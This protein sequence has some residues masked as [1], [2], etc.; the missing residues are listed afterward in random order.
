MRKNTAACANN[1]P[2]SY[3]HARGDVGVRGDPALTLYRYLSP[4]N[5]EF[6]MAVVMVAST[7]IATLR[8][9]SMCAYV[10]FSQAVKNNVV[11]DPCVVSN[12]DF[13]GVSNSCRRA[14]NNSL[15][16]FCAE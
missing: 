16:D 5:G 2:C 1:G 10:D 13:P 9:H 12:D 11:P 7:D 8:Y 14:D 4:S 6:Y 3:M 15:A